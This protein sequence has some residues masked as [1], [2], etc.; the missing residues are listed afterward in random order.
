VSDWNAGIIQ[1]FRDNAGVVG[2]VYEGKPLLLLT[3]TGAKT[4][5]LHVTPVRYFADGDAMLIVAS[6]GGA[7]EHPAW[8][9]NLKAN[10]HAGI[11]I[12]ADTA[13]VEATEV[14]GEERDR[15]YE[16]VVAQAPQFGDYQE[17]TTR[18]IPLFRLVRV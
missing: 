3:S 18:K 10:P 9:Y 6:K 14:V 5:N 11:E 4:G 8:F 15:L 7:D 16:A 12:G 2:G 13:E 1:E 17:K